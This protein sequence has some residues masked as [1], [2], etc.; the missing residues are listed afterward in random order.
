MTDTDSGTGETPALLRQA[1]ALAAAGAAVGA[2]V[3]AIKARRRDE[4]FDES[5]SPKSAATGTEEPEDS[6]ATGR[7]EPED[8]A[9][10]GREEPEDSAGTGT[11][12]PE[13]SSD[14]DEDE[15]R[16][17]TPSGRDS[18]GAL[19]LAERAARQLRELT[20]REP[21]SV[22]GLERRD[23]GWIATVELVEVG[24][25]PSTMDVLGRYEAELDES[26]TVASYHQTGRYLRGRAESPESA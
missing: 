16:S 15:Q 9:A 6:A 25:V 20:G 7:E 21:D 22:L 18:D 12:E 11:Q 8:S 14:P 1:V 19:G 10:T 13:D 3:G 23:G 26:G 5:P 2:V 24:R 17:A 4:D